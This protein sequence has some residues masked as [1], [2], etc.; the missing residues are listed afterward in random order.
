[1]LP[2]PEVERAALVEGLKGPVLVIERRKGSISTE[3]ILRKECLQLIQQT[4]S[5]ACVEE[6]AFHPGMPVDPRHNAKIH[7]EELSQWV[8]KQGI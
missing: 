1:M 4:P 2:H 5:Y 6:V 7:R 3:R 8:K